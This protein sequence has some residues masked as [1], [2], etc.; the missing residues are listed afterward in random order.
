M[1]GAL[2]ADSSGKEAFKSE[3]QNICRRRGISGSVM[4]H[5]ISLGTEEKK[6]VQALRMK[7]IIGERQ[8]NTDFETLW[9]KILK[10]LIWLSLGGKGDGNLK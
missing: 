10:E 3:E 1:Y 8:E 6:Q 5:G 2:D 7:M 9:E 4:G